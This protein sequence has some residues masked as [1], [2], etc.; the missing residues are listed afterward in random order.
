MSGVEIEPVF[1]LAAKF[2]STFSQ[3]GR[4][5]SEVER[6]VNDRTHRQRRATRPL[7][8]QHWSG[9]S[10]RGFATSLWVS[11]VAGALLYFGLN[12]RSGDGQPL[13]AFR[14]QSME[15]FE[16]LPF[17]W[18]AGQLPPTV[19]APGQLAVLHAADYAR[20]LSVS[21]VPP[22]L[23]YHSARSG[24]YVVYVPIGGDMEKV[25][26]AFDPAKLYPNTVVHLQSLAGAAFSAEKDP[27]EVM[28]W[29]HTDWQHGMAGRFPLA[30]DQR[31]PSLL[32]QKTDE[33]R[34][35]IRNAGNLVPFA[36]DACFGHDPLTSRTFF[37]QN[38]VVQQ[39]RD[40]LDGFVIV[41]DSTPDF[42]HSDL[43]GLVSGL[44]SSDFIQTPEDHGTHSAGLIGAA[45]N[46]IGV[47][48]VA[49]GVPMRFLEL[50]AV[51]SGV[52]T[53]RDVI[54]QL[55]KL[56]DFLEDV[57]SQH[58]TRPRTQVI[59]LSYAAEVNDLR[60]GEP[61]RL[62]IDD[63]LSE[64]DVFIVV[65]AGNRSLPKAV[66]PSWFVP[67]A[68]A[69]PSAEAGQRT[70]WKGTLF[71]VG[72]TDVCSQPA[73]FSNKAVQSN[74]RA[75]YVP[76]QSIYST[77]PNDDYGFISGTSAAASLT[78]GL[79]FVVLQHSRELSPVELAQWLRSSARPLGRDSAD[80][81][82]DAVG[83]IE[84]F[85]LPDDAR[86]VRLVLGEDEFSLPGPL[87]QPPRDATHR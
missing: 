11:A 4:P 17:A 73:W 82:V 71:P 78:A 46:Q 23:L 13:L 69:S 42:L 48:G 52:I 62:V 38:W 14:A 60:D 20:L 64:H 47:A 36:G 30:L 5:L 56:R 24:L 80:Y 25:R 32:L 81:I 59:L 6:Q 9:L 63:L 33:H 40:R 22:E 67:A 54:P 19:A 27:R 57:R 3:S 75:Y 68:W 84:R 41:H 51:E 74:S 87:P 85:A 7:R 34:H 86:H 53:F 39:Q 77:L 28:Q 12:L 61:L 58:K 70:N 21:S 49:P 16:R 29:F 10:A 1:P 2:D 18:S 35:W 45:R 79:A 83:V 15:L 66:A 65:P 72:A 37:A 44:L 55:A 76:G 26:S 50:K 43:R 8:V 31:Y